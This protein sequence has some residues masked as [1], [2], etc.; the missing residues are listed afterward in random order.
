M[1]RPGRT[2]LEAE[3]KASGLGLEQVRH[4]RAMKPA[5]RQQALRE[6]EAELYRLR[7]GLSLMSAQTDKIK[8][9]E[10]RIA[11]LRKLT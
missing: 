1:K 7:G 2:E 3:A 5:E 4:F 9:H 8:E 6:T 10:N 11:Y